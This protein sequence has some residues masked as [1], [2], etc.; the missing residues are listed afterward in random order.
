MARLTNGRSAR[1]TLLATENTSGRASR[2]ILENTVLSVEHGTRATTRALG[3][4]ASSVG[5]LS[6]TALRNRLND[7]SLSV[8]LSTS[9]A[10]GLFSGT[11]PTA[12]LVIVSARRTVI[13]MVN[14]LEAGV[15]IE[16]KVLVAAGRLSTSLVGHD[17]GAARARSLAFGDTNPPFE[18]ESRRTRRL[19]FT[20]LAIEES[21]L[22]R[23][24]LLRDTSSAIKAGSRR[25]S[26]L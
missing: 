17:V 19:V 15:S 3:D 10:T 9:R 8:P 7:A 4:D 11:N 24:G 12:A 21:R 20:D 5:V 25:T 14:R 26:R 23:W 2:A 22:T 13:L 18:I 16:V 1:D 6:S